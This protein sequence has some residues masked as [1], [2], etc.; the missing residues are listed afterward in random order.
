[1]KEDKALINVNAEDLSGLSK[2]T[3][4]L[5]KKASI[6]LGSVFAGKIAKEE[7]EAA[8]IRARSEIEITDLQRRANFRRLEEDARHQKNMESITAKALPH[9]EDGANPEGIENDWITNFYDKCRNVSNEE[10]QSLWAK[11]LAGEANKPGNYSRMTINYLSNLDKNDAM[12]FATLRRFCWSDDDGT[13]TP[14]VFDLE[15]SIYKSNGLL[16]HVLLHLKG[17][18]LLQMEGILGGFALGFSSDRVEMKY[19]GRPLY[20][21]FKAAEADL[22]VGKVIFTKIGQELA[23]LCDAEPVKGFYEYVEKIWKE[24]LSKKKPADNS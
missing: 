2:P 1:M 19:F 14:V 11:A 12:K 23:S 21:E 10:M 24:R 18:G 17:I 9:L 16:G 22:G 4:T 3:N 20:L 6:G 7:A 8:L 5:V 13:L 15:D